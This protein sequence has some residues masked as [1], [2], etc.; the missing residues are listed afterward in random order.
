M[1]VTP[2]K[3]ADI[4]SREAQQ[5]MINREETELELSNGKKVKIGWIYAP[6]SDKIDDVILEH[7]KIA[8]ALENGSI[9][10]PKANKKTRQHFAK[11]TAAILLNDKLKIFFFWWL[12]WRIIY[13]RWHITGDDYMNILAEAKKK[14]GEHQYLVAMAFSMTMADTWTMMTKK[15]AEA[16]LQEL[17]SVK[18]QQQ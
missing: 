6:T 17:R 11:L 12:K 5:A 7:D 4:E 14:A 10:L 8:K 2:P 1:E 16:F 15:E 13:Y 3:Q 9:D 18:E